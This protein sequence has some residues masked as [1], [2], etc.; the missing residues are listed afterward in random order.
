MKKYDFK[1]NIKELDEQEGR[2]AQRYNQMVVAE[3]ER[4]NNDKTNEP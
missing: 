3:M 1:I 4:I 2:A